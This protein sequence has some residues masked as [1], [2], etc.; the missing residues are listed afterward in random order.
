M[1]RGRP[2][3]PDRKPL[4][5]LVDRANRALQSHM[6][7]EAHR[8]GYPSARP[9][10]NVVFATLSSA[11]GE[12]TVD[13]AHRAGITRQSMG[14]VVRDLVD[15]GLVELVPDPRDGRA[16][17]VRYTAEG[18]TQARTGYR[19]LVDLEQR[20]TAEFGEDY[21]AT[22]RVLEAVVAILAEP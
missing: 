8:A 13:L 11:G 15:L 10:H 17:L 7:T 9:A 2:E 14:E 4:I 22:R 21:E 5:A 18:L 1:S 16:K 6:V 12:R 3:K 20:F 19:H